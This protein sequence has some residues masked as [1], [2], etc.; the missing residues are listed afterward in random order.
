MA[1]KLS[2]DKLPEAVSKILEILSSEDS[3]YSALPEIRKSITALERKVDYMIT[4]LSPDRPTMDA[5]TVRRILKIRPKE[6]NE[7][8]ESGILPYRTDGKK[9]LYFEDGIIKYFM[10]QPAW[11]AVA[12]PAVAESI[13]DSASSISDD[14]HLTIKGASGIVDRSTAAIYQL[15]SKDRIPFHRNGNNLYFIAGE[16]RKWLVDNPPRKRK[17]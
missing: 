5:Q 2:W 15:V 6:L 3:E 17:S 10:G 1:K 11:K 16:L 4:A 9:V 14:Q 7:L 8:T 13:P 12:K